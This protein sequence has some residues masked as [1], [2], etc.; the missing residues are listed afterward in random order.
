L[1]VKLRKKLIAIVGYGKSGKSTIIQSLTGCGSRSFIG[2]VRDKAVG[3]SIYVYAT[4]PQEQNPSIT[5]AK[6]VNLLRKIASDPKIQ[7]LVIAIQP[8]NP[9]VRLSMEV[10]F[11]LAKQ[12]NFES[13]AFILDPPWN[14]ASIRFDYV[15]NR[16]RESD[17]NA[18]IFKLNGRRFAI[19]N[20]EKIR[21]ITEL[22]R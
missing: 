14:K 7:G 9:T 11:Q 12:M 19:A 8:V 18:Y 20:S 22:P 13:Y 17:P 3:G 21:S 5:Q 15:S 16:I 1:E 10:I 4:S 6:F 2:E